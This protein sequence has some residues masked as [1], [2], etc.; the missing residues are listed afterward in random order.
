MRRDQLRLVSKQIL[1]ILV[2]H[3]SGPESMPERM[4]LMPSSA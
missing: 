3:P 4:L 1:T 2:T